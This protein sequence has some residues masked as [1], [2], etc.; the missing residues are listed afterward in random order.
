MEKLA[1]C[2]GISTLVYRLALTAGIDCR[3]IT[4]NEMN[5]QWNIVKY[6]S[7]Y[8]QLDATWYDC[9]NNNGYFMRGSTDFEHKNSDDNFHDAEFARRYPLA[10]RAL[11]PMTDDDSVPLLGYMNVGEKKTLV[12][13]TVNM[14]KDG[15]PKIL[16]FFNYTCGV[17]PS[18]L[19]AI[20]KTDLS[21]ID[22]YLLETSASRALEIETAKEHVQN[23][24]PS[25]N[26][27]EY[28]FQ[29]KNASSGDPN[30][31]NDNYELMRSMEKDTDIAGVFV[32]SPTFFAVNGKNQIVSASHGYS[33]GVL[34]RMK[35]LLKADTPKQYA[36]H[37]GDHEW[38]EKVLVKPTETDAGELMRLCVRCGKTETLRMDPLSGITRGQC[39]DNVYWTFNAKDGSMV[40]SGSGDMWSDIYAPS[41]T[42]LLRYDQTKGYS[43]VEDYVFVSRV[44]SVVIQPGIT[45]IGGLM[46]CGFTGIKEL[47]IPEGVTTIGDQM[48][49]QAL[50]DLSSLEK[51]IFPSTGKFAIDDAELYG[52]DK[53]K[54]IVFHGDA[55]QVEMAICW[56]SGRPI[57]VIY[58]HDNPSWTEEIIREYRDWGFHIHPDNEETCRHQLSVENL[59]IDYGSK[60]GVSDGVCPF[61]GTRLF[62][63]RGFG[64][65]F[66]IRLPKAVTSIE[67]EAFLGVTAELI[68][69]PE[70]VRSIGSRAFAGHKGFWLV[71]IP[72]SVKQIADDAF[73]D[74]P[75]TVIVTSNGSYAQQYAQKNGILWY[76]LD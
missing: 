32:H 56:I 52:C 31:A 19:D 46:L 34:D 28:I 66:V 70:S 63:T 41:E 67:S 21:G 54:T 73:E 51:I 4:S 76:V 5:H 44:K 53:L 9:A 45:S 20:N 47:V 57:E 59:R 61:C 69:L 64:S 43:A 25:S 39:G 49:Y 10:D 11:N 24:M 1:V 14:A 62:Q 75:G 48:G 50:S 35:S 42:G 16:V 12:G 72:A 55:M 58:P 8:Y 6:G 26:K 23:Q 60:M 30:Y 3:T 22:I 36:P 7:L 68:D 17:T 40:F 15:R 74:S 65:D 33:E 27:V 29:S 71:V 18:V 37:T 38:N 13:K 2:Q